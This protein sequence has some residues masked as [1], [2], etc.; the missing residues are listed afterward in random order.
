MS[1]KHIIS[2]CTGFC[3]LD[4]KYDICIGCGRSSYEIT[5]WI[6]YSDEEREKIRN[7]LKIRLENYKN[8]KSKK[9]S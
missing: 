1:S 9:T 2:P 5:H 6:F 7:H 8:A 3:R 4:Q